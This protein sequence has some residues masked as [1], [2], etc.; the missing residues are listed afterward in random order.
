MGMSPEGLQSLEWLHRDGE[1][2]LHG[3]M[4]RPHWE[5]LLLVLIVKQF[6]PPANW[7]LAIIDEIVG[8]FV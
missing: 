3:C 5:V 7:F 2:A 8:N 4:G 6:Y 1:W